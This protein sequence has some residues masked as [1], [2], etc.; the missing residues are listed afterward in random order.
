MNSLFTPREKQVLDLLYEGHATKEVAAKLGISVK[1]CE[2]H[3]TRMHAKS[4]THSRAQ[5]IHCAFE[6]GWL[7]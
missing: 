4:H 6:R 1:T 5:L 7:P 3:E 2:C